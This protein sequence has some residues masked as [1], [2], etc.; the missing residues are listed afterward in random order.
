MNDILLGTDICQI[1]RVKSATDKYG[2]KFLNKIFTNNEINYAK[3]SNLSIYERLAVRFATKEAVS[4]ALGVGINKMGWNKGIN[5]KDVEVIR[6]DFGK[7]SIELY[8]KAKII[9]T[10]ANISKWKVS[11]SHMGDY[12]TSTV[13]AIK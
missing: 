6:Q 7:L 4:K 5:W 8:G 3:Q 13:I 1:S 10:E 12:A 11:V 9:A 2:D